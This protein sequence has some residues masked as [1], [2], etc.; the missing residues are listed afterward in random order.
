[1]LPRSATSTDPAKR[2]MD[3]YAAGT[4]ADITGLATV[5]GMTVLRARAPMT[6]GNALLDSGSSS[7][8]VG[9]KPPA[10]KGRLIIVLAF[11]RALRQLDLWTRHIFVWQKLEDLRNAIKARAA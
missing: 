2:V 11:A 6:Q 7:V 3:Y 4:A 10:R 8:D 1:M 5:T 9:N